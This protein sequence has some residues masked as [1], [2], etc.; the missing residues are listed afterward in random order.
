MSWTVY[1]TNLD[2]GNIKA[3]LQI[4]KTWTAYCERL[5]HFMRDE[6]RLYYLN[7]NLS[8]PMMQSVFTNRLCLWSLVWI[9]MGVI[10]T[11]AELTMNW[12]KLWFYWEQKSILLSA[13]SL[14]W[15]AFKYIHWCLYKTALHATT[16]PSQ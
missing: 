15:N 12:W 3:L 13:Y 11:T 2:N 16:E 6:T 10:I 7:A 1:S 5:P 9:L 8:S 14:D 4:S